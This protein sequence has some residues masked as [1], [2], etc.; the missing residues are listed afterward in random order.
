LLQT[1]QRNT[2]AKERIVPMYFKHIK[3]HSML[4]TSLA[5]YHPTLGAWPSYVKPVTWN[6][7]SSMIWI[8]PANCVGAANQEDPHFE[9]PHF[10]HACGLRQQTHWVVPKQTRQQHDP[11]SSYESA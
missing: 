1:T 7:Q 11:Q 6:V 4:T 8:L 3:A 9:D 2:A 10:Q 5:P